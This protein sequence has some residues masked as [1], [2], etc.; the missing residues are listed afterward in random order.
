MKDLFKDTEFTFP[1]VIAITIAIVLL[2]LI[3]SISFYFT[4]VL[5]HEEKMAS[6]GYEQVPLANSSDLR[7]MKINNEALTITSD[8]EG[9]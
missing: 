2:C 7:W 4:R 9:E 1:F 8:C 5:I 3:F 6:L